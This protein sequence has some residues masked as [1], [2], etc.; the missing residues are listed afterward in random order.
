MTNSRLSDIRYEK[1]LAGSATAA[2]CAGPDHQIVSWNKAAEALL[3]HRAEDAVGRSLTMIIPEHLRAAHEAGWKRAV[4]AGKAR[5]A[6]QAVEIP[7]LHADGHEVPVDLS[8]S[9]WFEDG[10]P[11][12]GA[13]LR[14]VTDRKLARQRLEHLA[15][16]D[17][18]TSLPNR[19][20]MQ[21]HMEAAIAEGSCALL[22]LDLDGFKH[23][24]D[25]LGHSQG[26]AL[27]A[28]VAGR[29]SDAIGENHMVARLGGDEFA[30]LVVDGDDPRT[31]HQL[32][33]K[34]RESLKKPI[35]LSGQMLFVDASIG[36][37]LAP[38]D[39]SSAEE[40]LRKADLALYS[41]KAK[42]GCARSFFNRAMQSVS[43]RRHRLNVDLRGAL[44]R[45]EFQLLYQPQVRLDDGML[46]GVEALL[47][48]AHPRHGLLRPQE[49]IEAL[50]HNPVVGDVGD[51][52]VD[53][54]CAAA[55]Y[56]Q[57]T[58]LGPIRVAINLFARQ[59]RTGG[60]YPTVT[61]ALDRHGLAGDSLELEITES[62]VLQDNHLQI[63][64]LGLL[65]DIG[66][67]IAFDDFGT[68]FASLSLLQR[69][70]LT[71]LKIDRSFVG[72]FDRQGKDL[73][74]VDAVIT[75]ARKLG[76]QVI[77][78]GVETSEQ[79]A[80]LRKLNCTEAQGFLYGCPMTVA[81]LVDRYSHMPPANR[82]VAG[83]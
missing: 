76:L 40:L 28:L 10:R 26:D 53:Q 52:V 5:L 58:G 62:T 70:P 9:M 59:L 14:D 23:V 71:R 22:M 61:E 24:N 30:V 31:L 6:G 18:L 82:R 8:L 74:I 68:G 20:A 32:A 65:K 45:G 44:E 13:L 16:F 79:A 48:W 46:V 83:G 3:G 15:H 73:A 25:T 11:M 38:A 4:N 7:A 43:E 33:E 56:F 29:L 21:G 75:M 34:I 27:L 63:R 35:E 64:D 60:L 66:V 54:A 57:R 81:E 72:R 19:N 37:A 12:F 77:A 2:I 69:F 49:F 17:S 41:A 47:R 51:W 39:A 80:I 78:E 67:Q 55:S 42:G 1:M 50:E 36:I